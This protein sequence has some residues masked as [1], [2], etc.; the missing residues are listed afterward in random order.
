MKGMAKINKAA[1]SQEKK[2]LNEWKIMLAPT[3]WPIS[4]GQ[5][6]ISGRRP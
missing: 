3:N 2:K 6:L 4:N 5:G 1:C